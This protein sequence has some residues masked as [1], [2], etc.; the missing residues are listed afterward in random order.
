MGCLR[1]LQQYFLH[2]LVSIQLQVLQRRYSCNLHSKVCVSKEILWLWGMLNI[3][4]YRFF[5]LFYIYLDRW[6][7]HKEICHL[8]LGVHYLYVAHYICWSPLLLLVWYLI[9]QWI[10]ILP[11][12]QHL[13]AMGCSGRRKQIFCFASNCVLCQFFRLCLDHGFSGGRATHFSLF[14]QGGKQEG[15]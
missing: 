3:L 8:E 7:I 10:R 4:I 12:L 5:Y 9:M 15:K 13:L 11:S 6:R 14:S 2:I 1:G